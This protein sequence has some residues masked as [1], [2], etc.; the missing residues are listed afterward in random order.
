[1]SFLSSSRGNGLFLGIVG[2]ILGEGGI[3]KVYGH[4]S[5]R[6]REMVPEGGGID[7][8]HEFIGEGGR[9]ADGGGR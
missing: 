7:G 6:R 4:L 9:G 8:R 3:G 1:M 2:R 5:V